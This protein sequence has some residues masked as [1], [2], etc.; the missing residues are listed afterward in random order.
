MTAWSPYMMKKTVVVL[1]CLLLFSAGA[2]LAGQSPT[3][4]VREGLDKV[5]EVL[6]ARSPQEQKEKILTD[7][8]L[9]E[10]RKIAENYFDFTELTMRSVGK[11]WLDMNDTQRAELEDA[12]TRL[13]ERT[14]LQKA[15]EYNG[16]TVDYE[17]ELIKDDRAFVLT[18]VN[19]QD[20]AIPV[21]YRMIHHDK[22]MI[23]DVIIEG[24]SLVKNY[25]TQ[26]SKELQSGSAEQLIELLRKKAKKLDEK[27]DSKADDRGMESASSE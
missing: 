14:Y 16:E 22:W 19:Y 15:A 12:F 11:P 17:K 7:A 18:N 13:L 5:I 26:F 25:R 8:T 27:N 4:R 1:W 2:A 20:K 24:V 9:A 21:N 23:Y 6:D 3:E 10:L